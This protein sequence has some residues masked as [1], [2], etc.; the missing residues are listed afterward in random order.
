MFKVNEDKSIYMTRGDI[1]SFS[2]S[3][4]TTDS[5]GAQVQYQFQPGDTLRLKIFEKKGCD[6][7]LLSKDFPIE[8]A[9]YTVSIQLSKEDTRFREEISKPTDYWYEIELNPETYPQTIIGYDEDGPKIFRLYP[10][11][12]EDA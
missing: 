12:G 11:G 9:A 7:V 1:A 2:F 8:E 10:E 4:L 3:A 6:K 5:E